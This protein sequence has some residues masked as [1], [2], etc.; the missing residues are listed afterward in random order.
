M[1]VRGISGL[2]LAA[3][4]AAPLVTAQ[5]A[6]TTYV[7]GT[8]YRCSEATEER[9]DAIFKETVAPILQKEVAAGRISTYGWA[10]HW[11][12]GEWRRLEYTTGT[13]MAKMVD[14]RQAVIDTLTKEK[15]QAIEEF[16]SIC[17][18]HDDYLWSPVASSQAPGAVARDR[19]AVAMSTYFECDQ[20]EEDEADEIVKSAYAP[21]L[22][23]H[24]KEGKIV[25]WNWMQHLSGGKYR[26]ILVFDGTDHKSILAY[27]G[28]LSPALEKAHPDKSKRFSSICSSHTDYVWNIPKN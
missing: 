20:G 5:D 10:T 1:S 15:R 18:S 28:T 25:S 21:I 19:A 2:A 16:S 23:Q 17:P 8:Y 12:G 26:R 4:L 11:H 7:F 13:D 14:S 6:P 27:W 22:N 3:C 24:V 9:A